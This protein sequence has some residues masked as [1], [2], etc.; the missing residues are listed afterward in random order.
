MDYYMIRCKEEKNE[1]YAIWYTDEEDG[2]ICENGRICFWD[3]KEALKEYA[4]AKS[5][6]LHD[7]AYLLDIG[8]LKQLL[9]CGLTDFDCTEILNF[10]NMLSDA[11]RSMGKPFWG[12]GGENEKTDCIYEKLFYGADI[13]AHHTGKRLV[14]T[15]EESDL[16]KKVLS[17]YTYFWDGI[18]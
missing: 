1:K 2:F 9:A 12:N 10:W 18:L 17:Q 14:W 8:R 7:G 16:I 13:P 4:D 5:I 3:S 6:S 11:L 15:K